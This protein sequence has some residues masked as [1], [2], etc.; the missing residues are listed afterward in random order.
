VLGSAYKRLAMVAAKQGDVAAEAD[1]CAKMRQAY[2]DAE[3]RGAKDSLEIFYPAWNRLLSDVIVVAGSSHGEPLDAGEVARYRSLLDRKRKGDEDFWSAVGEFELEMIV[4]V[5]ARTLD[6]VASRLETQFR[7]LAERAPSARMWSSVYDNSTFVLDIYRRRLRES[8]AG[9][10]AP[11]LGAELAAIDRVLS[12]LG[13]LAGK[14]A[15]AAK[16]ERVPEV[17]GFS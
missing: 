2:A 5:S 16:G 3:E 9:A 6:T 11:D 10:S 4:A 12:V 1:A 15:S 17:T 13:E 8:A 14:R 7:R